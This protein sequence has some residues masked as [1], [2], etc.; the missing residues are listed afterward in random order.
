MRK[1]TKNEKEHINMMTEINARTCKKI[2]DTREIISKKSSFID[3]IWVGLIATGFEFDDV[4]DD[5]IS[6]IWDEAK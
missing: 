5:E 6:K 4:Y 2:F 1:L 3:G